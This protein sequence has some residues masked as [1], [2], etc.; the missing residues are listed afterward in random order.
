[1]AVDYARSQ[2]ARVVEGYPVER[3]AWTQTNLTPF[4]T[5]FRKAGFAEHGRWG[6][7]GVVMR[8]YV[9]AAGTV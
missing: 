4:D 3:A 1:V 9:E 6:E 2:G 8:L 7:Q 5:S